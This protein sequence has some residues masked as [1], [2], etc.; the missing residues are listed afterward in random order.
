VDARLKNRTFEAFKVQVEN[1]KETAQQMN[2]WEM[3]YKQLLRERDSNQQMYDMLVTRLKESDL[4]LM[5][6]TNNI[7]VVERAQEA[8]VPVKPRVRLNLLFTLFLAFALS[9]VRRSCATS[10]TIP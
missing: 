9:I 5:V 6:R 10:W 8:L 2:Q 1:L 3:D 7:R 4:S